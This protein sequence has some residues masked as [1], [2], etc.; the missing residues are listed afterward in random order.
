[1][2]RIQKIFIGATAV[3]L[4]AALT[5]TGVVLAKYINKRSDDVPVYA[6]SFYFE[7]NYL[8]A[9]NQHYSIGAGKTGF[10]LEL[11]NFENALRVSEVDCTYYVTVTADSNTVTIGGVNTKTA[12]YTVA[13]GTTPV[14]TEVKVGGLEDGKTYHISVTAIG[15]AKNSSGDV[16]EGYQKTLSA[17]F[18]VG[19]DVSGAYMYVDSSDPSMVVLTVWTKKANGDATVTFPAGLIPLSTD[20]ILS[21]VHNYEGGKYVSKSFTDSTS[22]NA[23]GSHSRT[24]VFIKTADYDESKPFTVT[25]G[26]TT[27]II[28]IPD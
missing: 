5:L 19:E 8:T 21:G 23:E 1:M 13:K 2:N 7:S 9:N 3:L 25:V 17:T 26:G 27:A 16:E 11:R 20:P 10:T 24:Y 4:L 28:G 14:T 18:T 15:G 12:T 6:A 22:F